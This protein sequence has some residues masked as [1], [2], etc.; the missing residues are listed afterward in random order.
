MN[1]GTRTILQWGGAAFVLLLAAIGT[2]H[3]V[4]SN[5]I[6]GVRKEAAAF[7]AT[8]SDKTR[9]DIKEMR[10]HVLQAITGKKFSQE[11][12]ASHVPAI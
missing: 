9:A 12:Y 4:L 10:F 3:L 6:Q 2:S 5:D 1:D 11:V 7:T 8:E